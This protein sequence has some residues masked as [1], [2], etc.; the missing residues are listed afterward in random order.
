MPAAQI[1]AYVRAASW[2]HQ[3]GGAR[4]LQSGLSREIKRNAT[5]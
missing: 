2:R 4:A 3:E 5:K 1:P